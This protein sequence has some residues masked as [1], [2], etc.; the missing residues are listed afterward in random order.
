MWLSINVYKYFYV[1]RDDYEVSCPEL[2]QL[3]KLA[4]EVPGVLGSRMTGGGFGGCT[5]SLVSLS[6]KN[7][8]SHYIK[9]YIIL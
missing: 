4:M 5:V 3:V 6:R 2:D 8:N 1:G 7:I 9:L